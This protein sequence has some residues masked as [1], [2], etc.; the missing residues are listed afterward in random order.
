MRKVIAR[1]P[2]THLSYTAWFH[3]FDSTEDSVY[4]IV[5]DDSTGVI[6]VVDVTGVRFL[7]DPNGKKYNH[8]G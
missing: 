5:E 7:N 3:G 2:A 6:R 8:R 4:A 1:D